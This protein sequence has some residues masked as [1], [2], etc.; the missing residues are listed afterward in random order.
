MHRYSLIARVYSTPLHPKWKDL[1]TK[2]LK[3]KH[4]ETLLWKTAEGIT[5]KP[6]YTQA[7]AIETEE[8]PGVFPYTRG[9][10]KTFTASDLIPRCINVHE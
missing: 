1:V 6:V 5:V 9:P 7:D 3:G 4:P 10:C 8:I 2:E